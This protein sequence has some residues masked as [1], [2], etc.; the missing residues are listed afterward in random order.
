MSTPL[1]PAASA[2]QVAALLL[3]QGGG[4]AA[5]LTLGQVIQARVIRQLEPGRYLVMAGGLERVVQSATALRPDDLLTLRVGGSREQVEFERVEREAPPKPNPGTQSGQEARLNLGGGGAAAIIEELFRRFRG[6]LDPEE[7][8]PLKRLVARAGR[9]EQMAL[10]GLILNKASLPVHPELLQEV[11]KTL[12]EPAGALAPL[13]EMAGPSAPAPA[14]WPVGQR[15]L[16]VQGGGAIAHRVGTV[17]VEFGDRVL[18]VAVALFEEQQETGAGRGQVATPSIQHRK[19][20]LALETEHLGRVEIRAVLADDHIR[21][22]LATESTTSTNVLLRN[23]EGLAQALA[24]A[25]WQVDG[26]S[27]ETRPEFV[28][29]AAVSAAVDHIITPGSLD[30]LI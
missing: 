26:I 5:N 21:V 23:G 2:A 15:I 1:G 6:M 9:P 12:S 19:V 30:R 17:L 10:S 8:E 16:N 25:G 28:T 7:T 4:G 13:V 27:H 22:A 29:N 14:W 24:A 3:Q 20:V 18:E 11:Y